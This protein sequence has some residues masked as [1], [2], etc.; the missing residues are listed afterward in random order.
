M[1]LSTANIG[2]EKPP[3]PSRLNTWNSIWFFSLQLLPYRYLAAGPQMDILIYSGRKSSGGHG[4]F[5]SNRIVGSPSL[6][7]AYKSPKVAFVWIEH[8]ALRI[9]IPKPKDRRHY[10]HGR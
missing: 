8:R 4:P 7:N 5:L 10:L 9:S 3:L 1:V 6:A 2:R